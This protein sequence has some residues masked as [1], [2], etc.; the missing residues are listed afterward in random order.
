MPRLA[1]FEGS[2]PSGF[3]ALSS[4]PGPKLVRSLGTKVP[5]ME[6]LVVCIGLLLYFWVK[7]LAS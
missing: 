2:S 5:V 3:G 6:V 1:K 4:F 7:S